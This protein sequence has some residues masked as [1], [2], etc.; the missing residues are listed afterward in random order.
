VF[1]WW[2]A[3]ELAAAASSPAAF[4]GWLQAQALDGILTAEEEQRLY[5][6]AQ[7]AGQDLPESVAALVSRP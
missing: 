7:V 5:A 4:R 2:L 1:L 6:A 3:Q